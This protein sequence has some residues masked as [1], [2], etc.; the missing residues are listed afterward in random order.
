MLLNVTI[1]QLH[2]TKPELKFCTGSNPAQGMSEVCDGESLTMAP[3]R[4]K[5]KCLSS[6]KHNTK[7][8]FIIIIIIIIII[9]MV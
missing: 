3:A 1:A 8:Q 5:A 9:I 6:V 4:N 7:K 2:S